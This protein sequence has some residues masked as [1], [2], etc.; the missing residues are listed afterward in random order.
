MAGAK[1]HHQI[2]IFGRPF[3]QRNEARLQ[4]DQARLERDEAR[5]E[6]YDART[7]VENTRQ[8]RDEARRKLETTALND[9][10][11]REVGFRYGIDRHWCDA[12]GI[13]VEG[14]VQNEHSSIER[15]ALIAGHE[16][17]TLGTLLPHPG[18]PTQSG[19][20]PQHGASAFKAYI[21]SRA[22]DVL[23]LEAHAGGK[24]TLF[25]VDLPPGPVASSAWSPGHP[26]QSQPEIYGAE[27]MG[28]AFQTI[29]NEVNTKGLVVCEVGSRNVSPGATSMRS[30]FFGAS[31]YIGVDIHIAENVDIAG[32][33]HYLHELVG[34]ASVDA[35][36]SMA[37]MEHLS[38]PWLFATSVNRSLRLGGITYHVTHQAFPIHEQPNDFWRFSDA[39]MR[40]LFGPD[41]GFETVSA[42]MYDRTFLYPE[43][44]QHENYLGIPFAV[45]YSHVFLLARKVQ[46]IDPNTVRWPVRR[47]AVSASASLYPRPEPPTES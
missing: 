24:T 5:R 31:K 40:V 11:L 25:L 30:T 6:L 42:G 16:Q 32:D 8:E 47:E 23:Q 36:F 4:R 27:Q 1:L 18:I 29:V 39:A 35:V 9:S 44:R 10:R 17:F 28:Q 45:A 46:N 26:P 3:L 33:A 22:T 12:S 15:L 38:H 37:V 7:E 13:Y 19:G 41:T 14:W 20:P 21:P 34:E 2:P 43:I